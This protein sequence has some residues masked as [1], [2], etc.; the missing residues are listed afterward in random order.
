[1][2][3]LHPSG[4]RGRARAVGA[5]L[6]AGVAAILVACGGGATGS[7]PAPTAPPVDT[8]SAAGDV[9]SSAASA[10]AA[11]T[12]RMVDGN[13]FE[14][15]ALTVAAGATVTWENA[16]GSIHTVTD[17]PDNPLGLEHVLPDGAQP[18]NSGNLAP[19]ERFQVALEIPGTYQYTCMLHFSM[20]ATI[21]VE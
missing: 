3:T 16:S 15:A 1:M 10:A 11:P 8:P 18:F 5:V 7:P 20:A 13:A 2:S 9:P 14:P 12:V 19:A 17:D 4:R 6:L 21:T